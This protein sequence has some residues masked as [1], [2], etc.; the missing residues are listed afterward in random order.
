[1]QLPTAHD[2]NHVCLQQS[3]DAGLTLESSFVQ[4]ASF[5]LGNGFFLCNITYPGSVTPAQIQ[6]FAN[7]LKTLGYTVTLH[8][9][10]CAVDW[11]N[12]I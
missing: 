5:A 7:R 8:S 4:G 3:A 2:L 10:F 11:S 1:M 6:E 9:T 12:A